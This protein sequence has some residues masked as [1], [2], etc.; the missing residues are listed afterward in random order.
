MRG[1]AISGLGYYPNPLAPDRAEAQVY[2]DQQV[3]QAASML[4]VGV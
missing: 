4:G 1:V 3:I 2:I